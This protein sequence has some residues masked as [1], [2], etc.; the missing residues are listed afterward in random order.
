MKLQ[1][2]PGESAK[3]GLSKGNNISDNWEYQSV[4]IF[5]PSKINRSLEPKLLPSWCPAPPPNFWFWLSKTWRRS[6]DFCCP[7]Q[8]G[9]IITTSLI[10][11][12]YSRLSN[13]R[14][15]AG[16]PWKDRNGAWL[17]CPEALHWTRETQGQRYRSTL[18]QSEYQS[19]DLGLNVENEPTG[20]QTL[21]FSFSALFLPWIYCLQPPPP[22]ARPRLF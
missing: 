4:L 7:A 22:S 5:F 9:T 11:N 21:L 10:R 15:F 13:P 6:K 12:L 18:S 17:L 19:S 16:V 1:T 3:K 20:L 2:F 14:S 8:W